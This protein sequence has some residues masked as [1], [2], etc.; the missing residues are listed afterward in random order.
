MFKREK[1]DYYK[2]NAIITLPAVDRRFL[3]VDDRE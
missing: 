1:M 3:S 2:A